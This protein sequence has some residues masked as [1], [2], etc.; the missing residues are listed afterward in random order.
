MSRDGASYLII[1]DFISYAPD[2]LFVYFQQK[3]LKGKY[4]NFTKGLFLYET[5]QKIFRLLGGKKEFE[6]WLLRQCWAVGPI[7]I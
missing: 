2:T 3:N 7:Q 6:F 5:R 4:S 1:G